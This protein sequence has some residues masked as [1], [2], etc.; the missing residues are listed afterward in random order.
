MKKQ[1]KWALAIL[2]LVLL[3][4]AA[5]RIVAARKAQA[6][7]TVVK[8]EPVIELAASDVM[9]LQS[10]DVAQGLAISG[11]LR[12]ANT[13]V[14]KARVAGELQGLTLREGDS[15]KAGQV[16]AR[17]DAAEYQARV[18]QA[19][20]SADAAKAQTDIAQRA[21]DN[22]KALV[23]QGFI[24]ATALDTSAASLEA[25]KSTHA[26]ALAA[27]D[28][29]RKSLQDTVL[30][31]PIAGVVS[32]RLAQ[33]GERVGVDARIIEI[34]DDN[35]LELEAQ[36]SPADSVNVRV[37]QSAQLKIE[38]RKDTVAASVV[39]INPSAQAASR[40]VLVYLAVAASPNLRQGLFAEGT[41]GTAQ[42]QSLAVPVSAVRY[43]K[44]KPYIQVITSGAIEHRSVELGTKAEAGG[45]AMVAINNIASGAQLT[46]ASAGFL[47]EGTKVRVAGNST[48]GS[49]AATSGPAVSTPTASAAK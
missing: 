16:V 27:A 1:W 28:I 39:R 42:M 41:L 34:V 19:Q 30:K 47:R 14:V 36:I 44:P 18:T 38:G 35:R 40:S 25:A 6:A 8:A 33:P 15:V 31:A 24:S 11:S 7:T 10:I 23:N 21:F 48:T 17:I 2:A 46:M 45:V 20:R 26:S 29:A 9:T 49:T 13:A 4:G 37:G 12:A 22:N 5:A 32:Q 3:G 43:D